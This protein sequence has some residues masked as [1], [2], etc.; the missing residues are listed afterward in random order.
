MN[1]LKDLDLYL[2]RVAIASLAENNSCTCK[3]QQEWK[4]YILIDPCNQ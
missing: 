3:V 4:I 2:T 1:V